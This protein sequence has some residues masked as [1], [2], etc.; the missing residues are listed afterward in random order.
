MSRPVTTVATAAQRNHH[1]ARHVS[2]SNALLRAAASISA[3]A[4]TCTKLKK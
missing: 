2:L 4:G 1:S 3:Y